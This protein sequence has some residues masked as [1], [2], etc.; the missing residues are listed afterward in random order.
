M[1]NLVGSTSLS[2]YLPYYFDMPS[3]CN[4]VNINN[5]T[6]IGGLHIESQGFLAYM[7]SYNRYDHTKRINRAIVG[8]GADDFADNNYKHE[9][10]LVGGYFS[11]DVYNIY[12]NL[13][14]YSNIVG[15]SALIFYPLPFNFPFWMYY[16]SEDN[17]T[18]LGTE[19]RYAAFQYKLNITSPNSLPFIKLLQFNINQY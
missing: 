13:D 14:T 8:V 18:T 2:S 3:V 11:A 1:T 6:A 7:T 5:L 17:A 12:R 15:F 10:P 4:L 9:L 16:R 19:P